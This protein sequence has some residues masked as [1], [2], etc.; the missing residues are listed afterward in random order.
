MMQDS[1]L[2][3]R[4]IGRWSI[5]IAK[6]P[7]VQ[8][9]CFAV[10]GFFVT[11]LAT[12]YLWSLLHIRHVT[13]PWHLYLWSVGGF[14]GASIGAWGLRHTYGGPVYGAAWGLLFG[15]ILFYWHGSWSMMG[16][17]DG[18]YSMLDGDRVAGLLF[19]V[20]ATVGG[21]VGT[22]LAGVPMPF[23]RS[24]LTRKRILL[25]LAGGVLIVAYWLVLY[26]QW[27]LVWHEWLEDHRG[28]P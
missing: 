12:N 8:K 21:C 4:G 10:G 25:W 24:P 7:A 28:G 19:F 1:F 16:L 17:P 13:E 3:L 20:L 23:L 27:W 9:T 11:V 14:A 6:I 26:Y 5:K 2:T 15:G 18:A 22:R